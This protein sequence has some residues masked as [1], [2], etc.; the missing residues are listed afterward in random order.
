MTRPSISLLPAGNDGALPRTAGRAS[1]A[2]AALGAG[3]LLALLLLAC[4][5]SSTPDSGGSTPPSPRTPATDPSTP[6]PSGPATP[7]PSPTATPDPTPLPTEPPP[8]GP[9][10]A[11][12]KPAF[13]GLP[14]LKLPVDLVDVPGHDLFLIAV[15]DGVVYAVPRDGPYDSPRV[16]HDQRERTLRFGYEEGFFSLALDPEF[17][18]NG[19]VYA[20]YSHQPGPD[21]RST[22]LVRFETKG[23]GDSFAIDGDSELIILEV[24]QPEWPHNGG[25]LAFG[26][27]GTL[28]LGLGD[29]GGDGDPRG[30]GQNARTLLGTIIRIDVR[31]A[32]AG[33]PYRIPPD[34][35]FVDG[36]GG[37]PEIWVYGMRNPWRISFDP[38]TE[39]LWAGDVGHYAREEIDV[40]VPGSNYGWSVMEGALCFSPPEGCDRTGLTL[41]VWDYGRSDGCAIIGGHVYRGDAIPSLRGW[42]VFSDYC[43]GRIWAIHAATAAAREFVEPVLLWEGG[44]GFVL[45]IARDSGGELYLLSGDQDSPDR[46]YRIVPP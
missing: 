15:Q 27:D 14:A 16:V 8:T 13:P 42:Y 40:I 34:N 3:V 46:I 11:S 38:E 26:P 7:L 17:D 2:L 36:E 28:Y 20:Y 23:Q 43:T 39:L 37:L 25:A 5:D 12:I 29:G 9:P 32:T 30:H 1:S 18:R 24:P 21:E 33:A 45:S 22:R 41:P 6:E 19:Y 35:P 31:G 10:A 4:G 44:P